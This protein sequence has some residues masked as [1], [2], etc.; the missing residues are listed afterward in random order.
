M[1]LLK[2]PL[3]LQ[4]E[5]PDQTIE[6]QKI[7]TTSFTKPSITNVRVDSQEVAF[8]SDLE[9]LQVLGSGSEGIVYKVR[10][11]QTSM[12]YALK[13]FRG[14]HPADKEIEILRSM[15]SP[16]IVGCRGIFEES[17]GELGILLEYMDGGSLDNLVKT[18]GSFPEKTVAIIAFQVLTGLDYLHARKIVHC[19]IKPANL[20][21]D[22]QMNVKIADFG[23]SSKVTGS[24]DSCKTYA[25]TCAYMSPERFDPHTYGCNPFAGDVW[26]LGLTL[27]EL[28]IGH[29]PYLKPGEKAESTA[30]MFEICMEEPPR[31][32]DL[33]SE[34]FQDF[35][36]CCLQKELDKRWSVSQLLGHPFVLSGRSLALAAQGIFEE[37]IG[38]VGILFEY[39]DAGSLDNLFKTNGSL[40]EDIIG[41]IAFQALT[42]LDHLHARKIVHCDIKPRSCI[43]D[44][45]Y[46]KP[47]QKAESTALM[48]EISMEEPPSLLDHAS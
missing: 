32:P 42:G 25:G 18:K 35:I 26:S 47:G 39:M 4:I 43:F 36:Q 31:L 34:S 22:K 17:I 11:K 23:V 38:E 45:P 41:S 16:S 44:I 1:A 40:T 33:A 46:L 6:N 29:Y 37:T 20:L 2:K 13:V 9:K 27:M 48:S 21:V 7:F 15:N 14:C 19:D 8:Q 10:D 28:Y 3:I 30:L 5:L 12:L 24:E